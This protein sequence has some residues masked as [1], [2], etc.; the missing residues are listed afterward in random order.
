VKYEP[1]IGLEVHVQ[2]N[3]AT[4]LF[5]SCEASFGNQP[6]TRTC[7]V[8]QAHPGVLPVFNKEAL[9]KAVQAGLA[10]ECSISKYSKFDRKNYFYPDLPKAYQISQFELPICKDGK[11]DITLENDSIKTIRINRI[12]ME[13]D[14]GKLV[15][16]SISGVDESYVDLNRCG[17]P[18]LEIVSEPDLG[19]AE[20]AHIYLSSLKQILEYVGASDC[21]MEKGS[22]RCDVNVSIRPVGQEKLGT[23]TEVKNV[24]SFSNVRKAIEYEIKRQTK[25]LDKGEKIYQETLL[26]DADKEKTFSMRDKEEAHDYRYFPDP[27]L[28]PIEVTDE[29]IKYDAGVLTATRELSEYFEEAIKNYKGQPKKISNWIMSEV[30]RELKDKNISPADF[31]VK[32]SGIAE[33]FTLQDEGVISGKIAKS[34]F[35]DMVKTGDTPASIIDRK[36]LKQVSDTG[37]LEAVIDKII[38]VNPGPVDQYKSGKT[39]VLGFFVGQVMKETKGQA[40][41]GI[42]N[43]LLIEKLS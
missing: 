24:N 15:H 2:L 36:G 35:E 1:V 17:V 30:L 43:K 9:K 10:T 28:V 6:N 41:P 21:D 33:L 3:T 34:V 39:N 22:L 37:E 4:K 14:A 20:E 13:E 42:V 27:D 19:S 26:W 8:C 40:N 18:L 32:P 25:V 29:Y 7:P 31:I 12:H 38:A 5:C 16:S 11:I 23:R